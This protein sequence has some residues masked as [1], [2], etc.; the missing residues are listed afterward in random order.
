VVNTSDL[1]ESVAAII[2]STNASKV[3]F[4]V[5]A[6]QIVIL[7]SGT[8]FP[9]SSRSNV[10]TFDLPAATFIPSAFTPNNDGINDEFKAEFR[11]LQSGSMIIYNRW[12][13]I[14]FETDD[15]ANGWDGTEAS[16]SRLAPVGTYTYKIQSIGD[17]NEV[18]FLTGSVTLIR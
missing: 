2:S 13:S 9:F 17:N 10:Y 11:F 16:G 1:S 5:L 7:P 15:L 8:P 14:I 6:T 18:S 3:S 12:G 4:R